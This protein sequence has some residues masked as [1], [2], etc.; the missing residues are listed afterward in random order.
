MI[1]AL[2]TVALELS[3]PHTTAFAARCASLRVD[4]PALACAR[5]RTLRV[6][7]HPIE[8]W[9]TTDDETTAVDFFVAIETQDG[10]YVTEVFGFEVEHDGE[11]CSTGSSLSRFTAAAVHVGDAHAARIEL[12]VDWRTSCPNSG[13]HSAGRV[14][15]TALCVVDD[16]LVPHCEVDSD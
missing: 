15:R 6:S 14:Y 16:A 13:D 2:A 1:L 7:G 11:H 10:W 3:G 8:I 12:D 9:R 4:D 5:V